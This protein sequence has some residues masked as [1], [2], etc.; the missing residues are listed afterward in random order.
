[1]QKVNQSEK[2]E[3]G[4]WEWEIGRVAKRLV[5]EVEVIRQHNTAQHSATTTQQQHMSI[6]AMVKYA[7]KHGILFLCRQ[8]LLVVMYLLINEQQVW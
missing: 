6:G 3:V 5:L 2:V 1:M 7:Y 4:K 8:A